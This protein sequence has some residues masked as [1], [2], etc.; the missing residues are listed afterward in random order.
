MQWEFAE[1]LFEDMISDFPALGN[2]NLNKLS[3]IISILKNASEFS[4]FKADALIEYDIIASD[5]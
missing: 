2:L 3:F 1:I 4:T 5:F